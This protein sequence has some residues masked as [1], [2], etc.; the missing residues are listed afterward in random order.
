MA[1]VIYELFKEGMTGGD[2]D[3]DRGGGGDTEGRGSVRSV[4]RGLRGGEGGR[5]FKI[6]FSCCKEVEDDV[7]RLSEWNSFAVV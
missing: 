2:D 4:R 7:A 5:F 1:G 3:D 6:N